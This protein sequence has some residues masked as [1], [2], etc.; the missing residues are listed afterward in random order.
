MKKNKTKKVN[1]LKMIQFHSEILFNILAVLKYCFEVVMESSIEIYPK[2]LFLSSSVIFSFFG[3]Y[4]F[5]LTV[6]EYDENWDDCGWGYLPVKVA[7]VAVSCTATP[8]VVPERK[9]RGWILVIKKTECI[10]KG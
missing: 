2:L 9:F 6:K 8:L 1:F 3:T 10:D 4:C 5:C 7:A